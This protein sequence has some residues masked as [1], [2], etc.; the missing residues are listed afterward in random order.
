MIYTVD[1]VNSLE[2]ILDKAL[3]NNDLSIVNGTLQLITFI[4]ASITNK[5]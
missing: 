4:Q 5:L 2:I 3:E 1:D